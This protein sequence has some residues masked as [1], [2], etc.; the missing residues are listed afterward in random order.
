MTAESINGVTRRKERTPAGFLGVLQPPRLN[1]CCCM[2]HAAVSVVSVQSLFF[3]SDII[4]KYTVRTKLVCRLKMGT[5]FLSTSFAR[6]FDN[7]DV[8]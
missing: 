2:G 5:F 7:A 8:L 1:L 4:G 3:P 6:Y